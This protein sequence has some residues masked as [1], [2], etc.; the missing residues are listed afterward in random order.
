MMSMISFLIQRL[1]RLL[2]QLA[3]AVLPAQLPHRVSFEF[4]KKKLNHSLFQI[5]TTSSSSTSTSSKIY[6]GCERK[7]MISF[8]I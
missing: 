1:A 3:L 6:E 2:A 5:A 4:D 7:Y 8:A